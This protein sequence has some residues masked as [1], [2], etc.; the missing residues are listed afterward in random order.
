VLK[1]ND[2]VYMAHGVFGRGEIATSVL[3]TGFTESVDAVCE[4]E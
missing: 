1:L 3:L 2:G 4:A